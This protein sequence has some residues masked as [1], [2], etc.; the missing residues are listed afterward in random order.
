MPLSDRF[1]QASEIESPPDF[2]ERFPTGTL[3]RLE[4][5]SFPMPFYVRIK[6]YSVDSEGVIASIFSNFEE[7]IPLDDYSKENY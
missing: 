6:G 1:D 3:L 7:N 5:S 2:L 4:M